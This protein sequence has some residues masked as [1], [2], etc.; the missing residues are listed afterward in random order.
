MSMRILAN[1]TAA[2]A[3]YVFFARFSSPEVFGQYQLIISIISIIYIF[4]VPGLN[5]S[6][7]RSVSRGY[8]GDYRDAVRKSFL[9][10]LLGVPA[11]LLVG[12]YYYIFQNHALGF[13]LMIASIFFP[14]FYAPNTWEWFLQGKSRF[15]ILALYS[16]VQSLVNAAT[17][18][19]IIV[20]SGNNLVFITAAY[21]ISYTFFNGV[22]Y[23][24]SLKYVSNRKKDNDFFN[25]GW[26]LTKI[27]ILSTIANNVDKILVGIFLGPADLAI[28]SV[29]SLIAVRFRDTLKS[30]VALMFPKMANLKINFKEFLKIQRKNI[31]LSLLFFLVIATVYYFTIPYVNR[32]MF[33]NEYAQYSYFSQIF[34]VNVFLAIPIA[35]LGYY[36]NAIKNEFT[37]IIT[38]PVFSVVKIILNIYMII[39]FGLIGA[40]IAFNL[41]TVLWFLLHLFGLFYSDKKSPTVA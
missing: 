22:Y 13:S 1:T 7:L 17:T 3:I 2:L 35:F 14:F 10:S 28:Y 5:T 19:L 15:D 8:D 36:I 9:G 20:L 26:F 33:T 6:L 23:L 27:N 16:S 40:V 41:T 4:S 38:N 39:E 34:S 25:Y 29:I 11:L 12:A 24:K 32:L 18:I 21:L 37:I 31:S 30:L